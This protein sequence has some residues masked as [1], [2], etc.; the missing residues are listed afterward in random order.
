[1]ICFLL[2]ICIS[3]PTDTGH[4]HESLRLEE[5]E[6]MDGDVFLPIWTI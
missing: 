6:I 5:E 1:M 2:I 3:H 4:I